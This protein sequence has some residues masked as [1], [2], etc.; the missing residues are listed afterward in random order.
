[1][2]NYN[3]ALCICRLIDKGYIIILYGLTDNNYILTLY[4]LTDKNYVDFM[5]FVIRTTFWHHVGFFTTLWHFV[6]LLMTTVFI[7]KDYTLKLCR[8]ESRNC[9]MID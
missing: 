2:K 4:G 8:L 9:L 5:D 7:D 6:S 3:W 1:M